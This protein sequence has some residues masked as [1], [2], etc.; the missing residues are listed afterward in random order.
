MPEINNEEAKSFFTKI[1]LPAL[2]AISMKIAIQSR[3]SKITIFQVIS[4][5][6][7]GIGS[8]YLSA[9]WVMGRFAD[10]SIP[11]IIA[12]ITISGEKIGYYL[13]YKLKIEDLFI[14][15][16]KRAKK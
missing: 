13:I 12:I 9:G 15:I 2:V 6:I 4:S 5:F 11:L 3:D 8:A 10:E 1:I 14:F 7:C 16:I